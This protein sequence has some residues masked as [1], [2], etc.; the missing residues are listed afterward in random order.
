MCKRVLLLLVLLSTLFAT[1]YFIHPDGSNE[2]NG[3]RNTP[4]KVANFA[5]EQ[6]TEGDT[7]TL[8]AGTYEQRI[9][10]TADR[11]PARDMLIRGE[12]GAILDGTSF[13]TMLHLEGIIL[14]SHKQNITLK[15]LT[16]RNSYG[17]G[18]KAYEGND[19]ITIDSCYVTNT[20]SSGILVWFGSNMTVQNNRLYNTCAYGPNFPLTPSDT[21]KGG[22]QECLS[23]SSIDTFLVHN[24]N[25]CKSSI[26]FDGTA[27][28]GGGEGLDIKMSCNNGSVTHNS[29]DS[30]P[31]VGLYVDSYSGYLH[32][33]TVSGNIVRN[34][35]F[36][37]FV[38][39]ESG[40][41]CR[42]VLI[43]NNIVY[44]NLYAGVAVWGY[45][46]GD[47]DTSVYKYLKNITV[48][49]NTIYDQGPEEPVDE[50]KFHWW[51][52]GIRI[53]GRKEEAD[54]IYIYGN[55]V[56]GNLTH[57]I[58]RDSISQHINTVSI[59]D[60]LEYGQ[61]PSKVEGNTIGIPTFVDAS[62]GNFALEPGSPGINAGDPLLA[63][64]TDFWGTI[65]DLTKPVTLGAIDSPQIDAVLQITMK[66]HSATQIS[67]ENGMLTLRFSKTPQSVSL[68]DLRGRKL[69]T[70][71]VTAE[72][73]QIPLHSIA[74]GPKLLMQE[75]STG[76]SVQKVVIQ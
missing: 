59:K 6:L 29:I 32:D 72:R 49:Y 12:E 15:N 71:A 31:T 4:W 41:T 28:D 73:A 25:I 37:I 27:E 40:G 62:G 24:N 33:V 13:D 57:Q 46:W 30:I 53:C 16:V 66:Q 22:I 42:R 36:G 70:H 75:F 47:K 63:P 2:N 61:N 64:A 38:A 7:L 18:I 51:G 58:D 26:G 52:E 17:I 3:S 39:S 10:F 54:S 11:G 44:K 43:E 14:I 8:L 9:L 60:N 65:R 23:L 56:S 5:L 45:D 76:T 50:T 74:A 68:Y 34:C 69:L 55:I 21:A 35:R 48:R 67:Q 20:F 1:E 19:R